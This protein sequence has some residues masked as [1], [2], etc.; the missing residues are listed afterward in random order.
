MQIVRG[1]PSR[2]TRFPIDGASADILEGAVVM[3][4]V[5]D[6]TNRSCAILADATAADAIGL[7]AH[8]HDFSVVGD[9]AP[10][11]AAAAYVYGQIAVF[12]PGCE[13]AAEMANDADNDVDVASAT[14]TVIT[15]TSLEDDI[16]GSWLYVRAGTGVG[17]LQY[18]DAS[19]SGTCTTDTMTTTLD[20]TSKVIIMRRAFHQLVELD[21]TATK[22]KSTAAAGSTPWRVLRNEFKCDGQEIWTELEPQKHSGINLDGK[23][24]VFRQILSPANTLLN[25]LD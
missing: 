13:V 3:P 24:P 19:A 23:N 10:E 5:T 17:Q 20:S 4:G 7:M 11:D 2:L 9:S 15:I 21:S 16:D 14:A 18:L 6:E 8:L 12:E 22:I 1:N 25:P